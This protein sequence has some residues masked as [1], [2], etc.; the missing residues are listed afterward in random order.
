MSKGQ[1][2]RLVGK[3][4]PWALS[5]QAGEGDDFPHPSTGAPGLGLRAMG[6]EPDSVQAFQKPCC[7]PC[8][9]RD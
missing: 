2:W 8:P 4:T 1:A 9:V 7:G 6:K 5:S 3:G